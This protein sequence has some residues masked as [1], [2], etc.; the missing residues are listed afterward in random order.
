MTSSM[1]K[2][3]QRET[4]LYP[5]IKALLEGQGYEVKAEVGAADIVACRGAEDPVI[6]ELK[7]GFSLALIHQA[8]DRQ[9]ITDAVYIAVPRGTGRAFGTA[10]KR[11][12]ALCRRL[13]LGMITVRLKDGHTQV[14]LDPAPY[15]PRQSKPRKTHLL[16]EF[17]KRVGDP[18]Q[19]GAPRRH[20]ITAYRQDALRCV[21]VLQAQGPS[22]GAD[23][24]R[25][26]QVPNATRLMADNHYGW[27]ER[28]ARGVYALSPKGSTA[29][30]RGTPC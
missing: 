7:L 9:A 26:A 2:P 17:A 30:R 14:H 4:D 11:N 24:A 19:G 21:H 16:R 3:R 6:V 10:L 23:V 8:I 18:N 27:F 12:S 13:G 1:T 15:K 20:L 29:G 5:P 22:K 25:L 28:I